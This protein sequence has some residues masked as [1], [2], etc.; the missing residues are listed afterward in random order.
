[1]PL[2]AVLAA[3]VVAV[4]AGAKAD[5]EVVRAHRQ[6]AD[7]GRVRR[8]AAVVDADPDDLRVRAT[9]RD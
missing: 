7:R 5:D 1:V 4:E 9:G 3:E 6:R 2:G 8:G